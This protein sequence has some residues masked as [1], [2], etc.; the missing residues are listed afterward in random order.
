MLSRR[1]LSLA[2]VV[3]ASLASIATSQQRWNLPLSVAPAHVRLDAEHPTVSRT[4]TLNF[5]RD[6]R[7]ATPDN[8][9]LSLYVT[10]T[11]AVSGARGE[12][13]A[14]R[15]RVVP[16]SVA[17]SGAPSPTA[18]ERAVPF[19]TP[20]VAGAD[21][22]VP[23]TITATE[24]VTVIFERTRNPGAGVVDL[25]ASFSGG[26]GA[27]GERPPGARVTVTESQ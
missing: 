18:V 14:V 9:E 3:A 6:A 11:A 24:Q 17:A 15:V 13:S 20:L 12:P 21:W 27:V 5:M 8:A 25:T 26:F 4:Y 7:F 19:A 23:Y 22:R 1:A 2:A 10:L 16:A